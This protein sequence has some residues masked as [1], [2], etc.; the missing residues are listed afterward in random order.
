MESG[1]GRYD[2]ILEPCQSQEPAFILEFKVFNP[3]RE[4]DLKD[5]VRNALKQIKDKKYA[6]A[7]QA[8]GIPKPN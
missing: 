5:M 1:F 3:D 4:N 8:K 6:E 2:V 7:L